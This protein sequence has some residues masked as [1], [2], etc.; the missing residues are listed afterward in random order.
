[1]RKFGLVT[2]GCTYEV[3]VKSTEIQ[4]KIAQ[5]REITSDKM[6][7]GRSIGTIEAEVITRTQHNPGLTRLQ[8]LTSNQTWRLRLGLTMRFNQSAIRQNIIVQEK[9]DM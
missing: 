1:M 6:I 7:N 2:E 8:D 5:D 4:S 9:N 3:F